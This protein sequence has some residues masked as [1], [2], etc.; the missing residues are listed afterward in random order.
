MAERSGSGI[1][2][3]GYMFRNWN[4]ALADLVAPPPGSGTLECL[5]A[6]LDH[7]APFDNWMGV[8]FHRGRMPTVLGYSVPDG[9]P[10]PYGEGAYLLDPFYEAF[11]K[12]MGP[13]CFRLQDLAPDGL[14][15]S[16]FYNSYY[17][18]FAFV[19]EIGYLLPSSDVSTLHISLG[20]AENREAFSQR[21]MR[22]LVDVM[23]VVEATC[24][25]LCADRHDAAGETRGDPVSLR[26]DEALDQF[27][28]P[29]LTPRE[30]EVVRLQLKGHSI[31]AIAEM[32]NISPGT[33]RNHT[34][35]IHLKLE[36]S[37]QREMFSMFIDTAFT[38]ALS[39]SR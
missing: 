36:I 2:D 33:V 12:D 27:A 39:T 1:E 31:K 26:F 3:D 16:D 9:Q 18:R 17:R 11:L 32:L 29:S 13:G 30:R 15:K 7:L 23:P 37:S 5:I 25:R 28:V 22:L 38:P 4:R 20:R 8:V 21:E 35:S 24:A 34:K 14:L 19:D 6:A 10:D